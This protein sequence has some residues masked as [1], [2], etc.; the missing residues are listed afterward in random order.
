MFWSYPSRSRCSSSLSICTRCKL[1]S[2]CFAVTFIELRWGL[3]NKTP[4]LSFLK[5]ELARVPSL[6]IL[7]ADLVCSLYVLWSLWSQSKRRWRRRRRRHRLCCRSR[8][9]RRWRRWRLFSFCCSCTN[10]GT[11]NCGGEGGGRRKKEGTALEGPNEKINEKKV[12]NFGK[13]D[14]LDQSQ[15]CVRI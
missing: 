12:R 14:S 1:Y 10:G 4:S 15:F 9:R 3:E 13:S 7:P 5:L 6:I 2:L 8:C 11:L